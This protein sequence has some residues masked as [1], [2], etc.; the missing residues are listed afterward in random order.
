MRKIM[1]ILAVLG[2]FTGL[3]LAETWNGK[4]LDAACYNQQKTAKGC[5]ATRATSMFAFDVA[6]KVYKLED[7]GN[8]VATAIR[9]SAER[10]KDPAKPA[11]GALEAK[12]TGTISGDSIKVETVEVK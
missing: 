10:S 4:L 2:V 3:A 9:N 7:S 6:G 5:E 11:V 12:V 1:T 8:K